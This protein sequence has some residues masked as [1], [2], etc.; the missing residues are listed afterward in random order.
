MR[1]LRIAALPLGLMA[2]AIFFA[3]TLVAEETD[4]DLKIGN[5]A[6]AFTGTDERGEE[7]K[8]SDHIGKKNVVVYFYPADFTS[9]C[10]KQAEAWRD[11]MNAVVAKGVEVIGVSGD[12][13]INHKLFKEA[14]KLNFTLLAD[15]EGAIAKQF[16]V[17]TRGGGKVRPRGPDRQPILDENGDP[18]LLVRTA[19]FA[20][21]T[22]VV[23]KDGTIIYKNTKVNPRKD[24]EQVLEFIN[25]LN[26]KPDVA[27]DSDT[28]KER[29]MT[30]IKG[31][32]SQIILDEDNPERPPIEIRIHGCRG[33][34]EHLVH[35][36]HFD[37]LKILHIGGDQVTDSG[38]KNLTGLSELE[39]L[40]IEGAS[41]SG[42]SLEDL[43]YLPKLRT[44]DLRDSMVTDDGLAHIKSL[45]NLRALNLSGTLV[46]DA[47]L[48][49]LKPL[50]KLES[51][52]LDF[53]ELE[54]TDECIEHLKELT[55]LRS[56]ILSYSLVSDNGLA[57]L[58]NLSNLES[59]NLEGADVTAA[60]VEEFGKNN[61]RVKITY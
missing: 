44:L 39:T 58:S 14:W 20:R 7:W 5:A 28:A 61:P 37:T 34:D 48:R 8:S 1:E 19:T 13:V 43:M 27:E 3:A 17:P 10:T 45:V 21:W 22:F 59:L 38:L 25:G 33:K 11:N 9:G 35:L 6:P 31:L 47:G 15:G 51:L 4:V 53:T 56:L 30:A 26:Q 46:T 32:G 24:S 50:K 16:G 40:I 55:Q 54:L 49:H 42:S 36:K 57:Q 60:G 2:P 52:N 41:V 29:A 23:G 18:I 12:R